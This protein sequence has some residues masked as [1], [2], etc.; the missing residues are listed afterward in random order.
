MRAAVALIETAEGVLE[1]WPDDDGYIADPEALWDDQARRARPCR[2][3]RDVRLDDHDAVSVIEDFLEHH[4]DVGRGIV[5]WE[6]TG[7]YIPDHDGHVPASVG[8]VF[9]LDDADVNWRFVQP[10]FVTEGAR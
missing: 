3:H 6:E 7:V 10:V 5:H 1:V 2:L 4:V 8:L 9:D